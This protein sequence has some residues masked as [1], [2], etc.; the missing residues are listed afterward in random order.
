M[1]T[2]S[3]VQCL[4]NY[5]RLPAALDHKAV[6]FQS[7]S[8]WPTCFPAKAHCC[9]I[10][11]CG[12]CHWSEE[13]KGPEWYCEGRWPGCG[14]GLAARSFQESESSCCPRAPL[15]ELAGYSQDLDKY[16]DIGRYLGVSWCSRIHTLV[17]TSTSV[18]CILS[19]VLLAVVQQHRWDHRTLP[20]RPFQCQEFGLWT[21][22]QFGIP[23]LFFCCCAIF[24][25]FTCANSVG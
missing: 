9:W 10:G 12:Q 22:G 23:K 14:R 4:S 16:R 21:T 19:G 3:R 7:Q 13:K 15:E 11:L 17:W 18:A 6:P 20:C 8:L 2:C 24:G 5:T 1:D 25:Y